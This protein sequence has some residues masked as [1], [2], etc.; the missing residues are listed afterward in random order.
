MSTSPG[1]CPICREP[2]ELI[3]SY[4]VHADHYKM[5]WKGYQ[6][7]WASYDEGHLSG[8]ILWIMLMDHNVADKRPA[9]INSAWEIPA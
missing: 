8:E 1:K 5:N 9:K 7:L 3:P 4:V 2:L 6:A